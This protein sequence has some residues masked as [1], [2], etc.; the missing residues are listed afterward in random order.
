MT[1]GV[2]IFG[3]LASYL[4]SLFLPT[5]LDDDGD[6]DLAEIKAELAALNRRLDAIQAV[7]GDEAPPR[8]EDA[9]EEPG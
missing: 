5:T 7:L 3:V 8:P 4:A 9:G 1:V 2:G 6:P